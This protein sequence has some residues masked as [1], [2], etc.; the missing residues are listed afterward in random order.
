MFKSAKLKLTMTYLL[1]VMVVSLMFSSFVYIGVIASTERAL[2][3]QKRRFEKRLEMGPA[4]FP[5]PFGQERMIDT[6][7]LMEIREKTFIS[8]VFINIALFFCTGS[9]G[10]FVAKK[11]LNP[12]EEV[13]LKQ[14]RFISDAAHEIKTP[15]TA[16]K[17][18]L[19][20]AIRDKNMSVS[21]AKTNMKDA[22]KDVDGLHSLA[23]N[24]LIQSKVQNGINEQ[25]TE[26][27]LNQLVLQIFEKLKPI[28]EFKNISYTFHPYDRKLYLL[29]YSESLKTALTN[30]IENAA[31]YNKEGGDVTVLLDHNKDTAVLKIKDTGIG[32]SKDDLP[33]IFDPF[34]RSDK[35]RSKNSVSGY[36][37]GLAISQEV[38]SKH[39]GKISVKSE[40]SI[41]T[42][43][44]IKL[45]I[46]VN[47]QFSKI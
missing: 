38:V 26:I 34:Y 18:S 46:S 37:L 31:K 12:I 8:L 13:M 17:A 35:S 28:F 36:G 21:E 40:E 24:L 22:V 27:E 41:G 45:P 43:F 32:I 33:H 16:L 10:Y 23:E 29:G 44:E 39:G 4:P 15:L 20:V 14:K 47:S 9:L 6:E 3:S 25:K 1:I 19:E 7:T 5:R 42:E 11:T 30:I 2:E